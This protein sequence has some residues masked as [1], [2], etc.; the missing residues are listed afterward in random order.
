MTARIEPSLLGKMT[1]R[2]VLRVLQQHGPLSRAEVARHAELSA[3]AVSRAVASLLKAGLLEADAPHAT[4]GR[5]A[6]RLR[7]AR[8]TA[9][10]LG[11]VIDAGRCRLVS[12][13][14]DGQLHD[15]AAEVATPGSYASLLDMLSERAR[16][17]L[18]RAE[19]LT[20]GACLSVPGLIDYRNGRTLLSPN[21]PITD[22]QTPGIDLARRLG[23][24]CVL[25]Q[26]AHALCLAELHYGLAQGL[27]DFAVLDVTTG[28]GLGVVSGGRILTGHSGLAG[29]IGH[30]TVI[31][32]GGRR[33][34]CG[35]TGC[36][37]TVANDSSL[38]WRLSR[39]LG[40]AGSIDDVIRTARAGRLDLSAE[41]ADVTRFLALGVAAVL[42]LFNP[43]RLFV[44]GRLFE[45]DEGLFDKMVEM[46]ARRTLRPSFADC[47]VLRA[48]AQ[49]DQG[50][51]AGIIQH[52]TSAIAPALEAKALYLSP[53]ARNGTVAP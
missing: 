48:T 21:V 36:L 6:T 47:R 2:R 12:A 26:E 31:P 40:R 33:C 16:A 22:G 46:A 4:G 10:V 53:E 35:N 14:L 25:L 32:E 5:P 43:S 38:A 30:V 15:D 17:L 20:L 13:G 27:G 44:Y 49:K 41:L 23:V 9:Q 42:N 7:L 50:A 45:A 34:G 29:E 18:D 8:R 24:E 28:V 1:E 19:V 52:L 37:E 11:V 39:R 3:P 51:I